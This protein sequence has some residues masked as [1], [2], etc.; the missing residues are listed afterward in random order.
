MADRARLQALEEPDRPQ[1]TARRRRTLRQTL[2]PGPSLD[3][4]S[5]R[6][7]RR[8]TRGLSPLGRGPAPGRLTRP[9]TWRLLRQ[10][11]ASL[12]QAIMP[13]PT[14]AR[15]RNHLAALYRHLRE[16]PRKKRAY[17]SMVPIC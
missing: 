3:H 8:R 9:E 7:A 10:L 11:V 6:A 1:R 4:P 13:E 14:F 5:A 17:Q 12:L 2:R 16:P 15:L